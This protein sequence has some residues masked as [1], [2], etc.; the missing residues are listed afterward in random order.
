MAIEFVSTL[1]LA[2]RLGEVSIVDGSWH[3]PNAGRDAG[4]EFVAGHIPG[5][6]FF[7]LDA[8]ADTGSGLPHMLP[9]PGDFGRAAGALGLEAGR[10]IVVYD[11]AGLFS[12]P[13]VA[14]TLSVMGAE[15]VRIL[16]GG[17]PRW[18]AEARPLETGEADPVPRRF[19]ARLA[20]ERV[21]GFDDVVAASRA[22]R[23]IVDARP[24][25]RFA[26]EV[27]EPRPGLRSGHIPN[28]LN[29]PFN[30]LVRDGELLGDAELREVIER[31]GIDLD[32]PVITSCGSGVTAA[33]VTLAL[34]RL[35][36]ENI[37]LYDGSWAEYG[38]RPDAEIA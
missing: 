14:W 9:A 38:S 24:A 28:S 35:G 17:L 21:A 15:D 4:A 3:L 5:A 20:E 22:H 27:P 25:A 13:R 30:L 6:V 11:S 12:A 1:W 26:G 37:A 31:A 18:Q 2:E 34:E 33:V 7:D 10:T 19:E 8:I 23:Q 32:R 16:S 36:A 29:L